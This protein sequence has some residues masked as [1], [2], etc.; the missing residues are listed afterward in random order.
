MFFLMVVFNDWCNT[1]FFFMHC[2]ID[3]KIGSRAHAPRQTCP[4][5]RCRW[6]VWLFL[7]TQSPWHFRTRSLGS[8]ICLHYQNE[9]L[10]TWIEIGERW[11]EGHPKTWPIELFF[12]KERCLIVF[13]AAWNPQSQVIPSMLSLTWPI[14]KVFASPWAFNMFGTLIL[15]MI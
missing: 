10:F 14:S 11:S 6:M 2:C 13:A 12:L 9:F 3:F 5:R 7:C 4:A 15:G 1:C 8:I